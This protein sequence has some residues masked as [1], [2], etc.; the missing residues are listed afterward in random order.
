[1]S[2]CAMTASR[3]QIVKSGCDF[4]IKEWSVRATSPPVYSTTAIVPSYVTKI[5]CNNSSCWSP[6]TH[7][8]QLRIEGAQ[9]PGSP[10]CFQMRQNACGDASKCTE[11]HPE[12][13]RCIP[14]TTQNALCVADFPQA[15]VFLTETIKHIAA[16]CAPDSHIQCNIA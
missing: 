14:E 4:S 13:R 12:M 11:V 10:M 5:H 6:H 9:K 7:H 3:L 1:M 15:W 8:K 16:Y 2:F